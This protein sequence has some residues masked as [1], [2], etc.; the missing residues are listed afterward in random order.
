MRLSI[1]LLLLYFFA[2]NASAQTCNYLAYDGFAYSANMP[3]EGLQGGTG[4][5]T[6][7]NVQSENTTLPGF[8]I[9]NTASL[10]WLDLQTAG[11]YASGGLAYLTAG[12]RLNTGSSGPFADWLT[13][14]GTI[15]KPG[16]TL[17]AS[18]L[19]RKNQNN[20]ETVAAIWHE[21]NLQWCDGC[22]SN[23][24][25]VG[26][27]GP[28]SNVGGQRRWTLCIHDQYYPTT[29]P[30]LPN[31]AAF[32]VLKFEFWAGS[33]TLSLFVDPNSLGN[34]VLAPMP[35]LVLTTNTPV[36]IRSL[37]LYLGD[38]A[39]SG[40]ADEIR[41]GASYA[42]TA[43]DA[44]VAVNQP[45]NAAFSMTPPTGMA[46]LSILFDGSASSDPDGNIISYT[47]DFGDGGTST[48]SPAS[49][50]YDF[51]GSKLVTLAIVDANGCETPSPRH[52]VFVVRVGL[53]C[54]RGH[55]GGIKI[56]QVGNLGLVEGQ[57]QPGSL[58]AVDPLRMAD[59]GAESR[60]LAA[61]Q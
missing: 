5:Q 56:A 38:D 19:L 37:A 17:W 33:T 8:Q 50:Q 12:R 40:Q 32:F 18:I 41:M 26:Y 55:D 47:W 29:V 31:E 44:S 11:N 60:Q 16:A 4:W 2:Q 61:R 35:I 3:L 1:S 53:G 49:H 27:F 24:V 52:Q 28:N 54:Q 42:C 45:P 58:A 43:P 7:W 57:E 21:S 34:D 48:N 10:N 15:G 23:K 14:D 6:P 39:A 25:A 9:S 46:P 36:V 59:P 22:T 51:Y 20:D 30:M 13:Q